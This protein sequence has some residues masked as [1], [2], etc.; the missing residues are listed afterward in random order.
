MIVA[1]IVAVGVVDAVIVA[2]LVNGNEIVAVVDAGRLK[3][4]GGAVADNPRMLHFQ[5]LDVYQRSI[6]FLALANRVRGHLPRV[7]RIWQISFDVRLSRF[8]R[9]SPRA[10]VGR[11]ELTRQ[12]T[13]QSPEAR[14]WSPLRTWT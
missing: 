7:T 12:G 8:H 3:Q 5:K 14:P 6:E 9:T 4:P 1:V 10:V 2:A 11:H 13:T